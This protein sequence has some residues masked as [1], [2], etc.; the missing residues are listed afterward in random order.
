MSIIA[1]LLLLTGSLVGGIEIV[2]AP[3]EAV[4]VVDG[5][6]VVSSRSGRRSVVTNIP[7][8]THEV[9]IRM[10]GYADSPP[11]KVE[12]HAGDLAV[13]T[14]SPLAMLGRSQLGVGA[15]DVRVALSNVPCTMR[16]ANKTFAAATSPAT[17]KN[18]A[19]GNQTLE[20]SCGRQQLREAVEV[21]AGQVAIVE[22]DV[23]AGKVRTLRHEPRS[24]QVIVEE[25]RPVRAD[26][27][28]PE[29]WTAAISMTLNSGVREVRISRA[30]PSVA[31]V[32]LFC[33]SEQAA[34]T[35]ARI[36]ETHVN[37]EEVRTLYV[38]ADRGRNVVEAVV[39]VDFDRAEP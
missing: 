27:D 2:N 21:R 36:I 15:G 16:I 5:K 28:V 39:D 37:V 35:F 11:H 14:L 19:A 23:A 9:R 20:I 1:A 12:V 10:T 29:K 6:E 18:I 13:L 7:A 22:A 30:G 33:G 4:I 32:R 24:R 31:R 38:I 17:A 3:A 8:G 25:S 26:P 34:A